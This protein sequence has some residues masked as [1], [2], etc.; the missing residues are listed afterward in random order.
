MLGYLNLNLQ[1]LLAEQSSQIYAV[2][3]KFSLHVFKFFWLVFALYD[4]LG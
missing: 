3:T 4:T 1:M 2:K